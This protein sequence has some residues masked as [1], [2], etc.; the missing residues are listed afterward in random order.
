MLKEERGVD[1]ADEPAFFRFGAFVKKERYERAGF[2]PK[3]KLEV[4][5]QRTRA[6]ARSFAFEPETARGYLLA[7]HW[8]GPGPGP[9]GDGS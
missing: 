8:P 9:G 7:R 3:T 5:A 4:T 2:N 1:W 6:A